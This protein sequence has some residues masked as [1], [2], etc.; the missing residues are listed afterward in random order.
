MFS[1]WRASTQLPDE[2]Y[3]KE[4]ALLE[5][6][7]LPQD[8]K[9]VLQAL[10]EVE[11]RAGGLDR[12]ERLL[13]ESISRGRSERDPRLVAKA[14]HSLGDVHLRSGRLREAERA[15]AESLRTGRPFRDPR[16]AVYSLAG[17]AAV[18]S[19]D[20]NVPRAGRLWGAVEGIEERE[21][22]RV[23]DG[24]RLH[25]ELHIAGARPLPEF[26]DGFEVGKAWSFDEALD[27]VVASPD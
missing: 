7:G 5:Q 10:G 15:Y 19:L 12:A 1:P 20:G 22:V 8:V 6:A 16:Y 2:L 18:A 26:A 25:Y 14:L 3:E 9:Y 21:Q 24:D 11:M 27:F 13:Q 23:A 4:I 17:I